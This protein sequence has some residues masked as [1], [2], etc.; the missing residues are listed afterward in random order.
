LLVIGIDKHLHRAVGLVFV[1]HNM[2]W[3]A[4]I[5]AI[6]HIVL[7]I[8]ADIQRYVSGVATKRAENGFM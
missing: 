2:D 1:H 4:A 3:I 6:F 8:T 5:A 7:I